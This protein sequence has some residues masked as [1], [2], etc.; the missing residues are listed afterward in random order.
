MSIDEVGIWV[1][2]AV[3]VVA[4]IAAIVALGI[5]SADRRHSERLAREATE[6]SLRQ[7]RLLFEWEAAKRLA[8]LEARGG[9]T[10]PVIVKGMGAETLA[11]VALLGPERVP[12]MWA[13]RV[14]KTDAE[15]AA[16][17]A[18]TSEPQF[19][20]DSVEAERAMSAIAKE[21]RDGA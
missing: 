20:R 9:H 11:L 7:A 14:G 8:I 15:L 5:A 16:F 3:V 13:R 19:L 6:A 4:G 10:D 1:Q 18:D 12:Q 21:I 2:V 17:I